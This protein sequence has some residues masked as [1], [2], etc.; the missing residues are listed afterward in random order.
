[1][2]YCYVE[3]MSIVAMSRA[4]AKAVRAHA[5]RCVP[6]ETVRCILGIFWGWG[7]VFMLLTFILFFFAFSGGFLFGVTPSRWAIPVR[8][9]LLIIPADL[10]ECA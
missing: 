9:A 1:M 5:V 10:G 4:G 6:V 3:D 8:K 7:G 2:P